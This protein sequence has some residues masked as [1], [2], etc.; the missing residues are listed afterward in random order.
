M[1]SKNNGLQ[2]AWTRAQHC[3]FIPRC[4]NGESSEPGSPPGDGRSWHPSGRRRLGPSKTINFRR[5]WFWWLHEDELVWDKLEAVRG[6]VD[7]ELQDESVRFLSADELSKLAL[8]I[9]R[10][11]SRIHADQLSEEFAG[12]PAGTRAVVAPHLVPPEKST[13]AKVNAARKDILQAMRKL[14][15]NTPVRFLRRPFDGEDSVLGFGVDPLA[16]EVCRQGAER[17]TVKQIAQANKYTMQEVLDRL[18]LCLYDALF[19]RMS[20]VW[21]DT[22]KP[23]STSTV[24]NL[25]ACETYALAKWWLAGMNVGSA[26]IFN[27]ICSQCACLLYGMQ[28]ANTATS[29]KCYGAPT[30][31]DG[32]LLP[33]NPDGSPQVGAQP[34]FL[35]R[36]SPQFFARGSAAPSW[37]V[38]DSDTN[39]LSLRPGA[40]PPWM[41]PAAPAGEQDIWL[42]C[43]GCWARYFNTGRTKAHIPFRDKASQQWLRPI[44]RCRKKTQPRPEPKASPAPAPGPEPKASPAPAPG[45][46][47]PAPFQADDVADGEEEPIVGQVESDGEAMDELSSEAEGEEPHPPLPDAGG[48]D[49]EQ[50]GDYAARGYVPR[51]FHEPP[52]EHM[53]S[54][55]DYKT[56]WAAALAKH[57][58][59]VPG[60]FSHENLVPEPI[61]A[62]WQDCPHVAG[63]DALKSDDAISRLSVCRPYSAIEQAGCVGGVGRTSGFEKCVYDHRIP[64]LVFLQKRS[65]LS[66]SPSAGYAHTTGDPHFRTRAPLQLAGTLGF[67]LGKRSGTGGA[68]ENR[69]SA[70]SVCCARPRGD[71]LVNVPGSFL[72]FPTP[73]ERR[74]TTVY[75]AAFTVHR[76]TLSLS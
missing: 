13:R 16:C 68:R 29:N 51:S 54:L 14:P 36:Y 73:R 74:C 27:G 72:V 59:V 44:R 48:S 66:L 31:R 35:L 61:P 38:H 62:L 12:F 22:S 23:H 15:D 49:V 11:T 71:A 58:R 45:P 20:E 70:R 60:G 26:P 10:S 7:A 1:S 28:F 19:L 56:A 69:I 46:H 64:R 18:L 75:W 65:S 8:A 30:N 2:K 67:V 25:H 76:R 57:S 47:V 53:R 32:A 33:T 41:R 63:F 43:E 50:Y 24:A 6:A 55:E 5:P 9:E 17:R 39:R 40:H 37:F 52:D 34:P 4:T 3:G 42:Y 21:S